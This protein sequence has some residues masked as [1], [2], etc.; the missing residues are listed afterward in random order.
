MNYTETKS[1]F[2][3]LFFRLHWEDDPLKL[4]EEIKAISYLQGRHSLDSLESQ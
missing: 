3:Q 2:V 1:S 4:G